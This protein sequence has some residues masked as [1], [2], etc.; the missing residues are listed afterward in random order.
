MKKGK[1]EKKSRYKQFKE[2]NE[3]LAIMNQVNIEQKEK[4]NKS[5]F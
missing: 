5:L 3:M 2:K 1:T 4:A